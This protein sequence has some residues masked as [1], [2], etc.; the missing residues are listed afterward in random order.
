VQ[1]SNLRPPA[2]KAPPGWSG[3]GVEGPESFALAGTFRASAHLVAAR[4]SAVIG[5]VG[6]FVGADFAVMEDDSVVC[7][8]CVQEIV[9][10]GGSESAEA[11]V[12]A[13]IEAGPGVRCSWCEV[14]EPWDGFGG[15]VA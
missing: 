9:G 7:A 14:G 12:H 15:W 2:C 5:V 10:C 4:D 13:W 3:K 8:D 1:G 11:I 6:R